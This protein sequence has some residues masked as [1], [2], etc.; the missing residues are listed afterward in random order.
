MARTVAQK[1]AAQKS[2]AQKS[3]A[4]KS[5]GRAAAR[6]A[7]AVRGR[8]AGSPGRRAGR[9]AGQRATADDIVAAARPLFADWG[10]DG[11]GSRQIAAAAGLSSAALMHHFPTKE[12]LYGA[13][14]ERIA[15]GLMRLPTFVAEPPA[16]L[17]GVRSIVAAFYDWSV[18]N[19]TDARLLM[20]E[21]L[22]N[23]DR[24]AKAHKWYLAG[25]V[26]R[27]FDLVR[28]AVAAGT[29][30]PVEPAVFVTQMLGAVSYYVTGRATIERLA[31]GVCD[32]PAVFRAEL[33]AN[34]TAMLSPT[35][36][37][38]PQEDRT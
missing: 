27:F 15:D 30:R 34:V 16:D 7:P 8:R 18:A 5:T 2:A 35:D 22:D 3:A 12:R 37:V 29:V 1:S 32:M 36:R 4:K 11:T 25:V 17:A 28:R 20:R 21:L 6:T 38:Q 19:Q 9:P 26:R 33:L 23:R 10:F 31:S 24:A 13:V 14:L